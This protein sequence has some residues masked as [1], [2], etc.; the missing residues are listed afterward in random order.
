MSARRTWSARTALIAISFLALIFGTGAHRPQDGVEE[1]GGPKLPDA[2]VWYLGSNG[3]AMRINDR[4]LIFDYQEQTDPNPPGPNE[5]RNLSRGYIDPEELE[6]LDVYVF[7]THSHFDH[8]DRVIFEWEEKIDNITY[9]FG[10]KA[11]DNPGHHYLAAPRGSANIGDMKVHTINSHHSGVPEAA[12]L[13]QVDGCTIFHNGDY[14]ADYVN[15][16]K[17][18]ATIT[19]RID[20]AFLIG[21]PDPEHAYFHQA[22]SL[23]DMFRPRWVFAMNREGDEHRCREW[24]QLFNRRFSEVKVLS[25]RRRGDKFV[26]SATPAAR[27]GSDER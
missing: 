22:V 4:L 10:W 27:G 13:V 1:P 8:F 12:F 23:A 7:V 24:G 16:Y 5:A 25:G 19:D 11:G 15:D 9:F 14:R 18:L 3:W 6:D 21:H 20:I 26:C 2:Q 17:Y